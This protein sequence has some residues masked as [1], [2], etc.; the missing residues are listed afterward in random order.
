M[1][2]APHKEEG[3][4]TI[5][6]FEDVP[7]YK[8]FSMMKKAKYIEKRRDKLEDRLSDRDISPE[9]YDKE[10]KSL[11]KELNTSLRFSMILRGQLPHFYQCYLL[12]LIHQSI[13]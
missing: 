3:E 5:K 4:S 1:Y 8:S 6:L 11:E 10:M 7:L 2:S 12:S 9:D 13:L